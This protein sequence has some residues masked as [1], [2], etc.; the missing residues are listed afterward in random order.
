MSGAALTPLGGRARRCGAMRRADLPVCPHSGLAGPW[1]LAGPRRRLRHRAATPRAPLTCEGRP[2]KL[3]GTVGLPGR[4][5]SSQTS[6]PGVGQD[7]PRVGPVLM[8]SCCLPAS[9]VSSRPPARHS[10]RGLPRMPMTARVIRLAATQARLDLGQPRTVEGDAI[11]STEAVHLILARLGR[12][13]QKGS[14]L[15]EQSLEPRGRDDFED[16]CWRRAGVPER[17]ENATRLAHVR[18][19]G[20]LHL[21]IADACPY[22][23]FEHQGKLVLIPVD[24][25]LHDDP[26]LHGVLNDGEAT[27]GLFTPHLEVNAKPTKAHKRAAAWGDLDRRVL[28]SPTVLRRRS[29]RPVGVTGSAA[30]ARTRACVALLEICAGTAGGGWLPTIRR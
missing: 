2:R 15:L 11:S 21:T 16:S 23:A 29:T 10:P 25:R 5:L 27:A 28:H 4:T 6:I 26:R 22:G 30:C 13:L 17:V 3:R 14:E 18:T 12:A 8:L 19:R 24:V 7:P 1:R 20:R 9:R